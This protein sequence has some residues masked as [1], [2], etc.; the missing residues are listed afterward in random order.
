M[1]D[2]TTAIDGLQGSAEFPVGTVT[3][4]SSTLLTV[5]VR[6]VNIQ[7]AY[8][9]SYTA[10]LAGDLVAL[11]RENATWLVLGALAGVGPNS[12]VNPSFEQ[13]GTT[14]GVPSHWR[15]FSIAGAATASAQATGFA[16]DGTYELVVA[17]GTAAQDTYVYSDPIAVAPGQQWSVS[18]FATAS[19]PP[20]APT[21]ADI[22]LYGL[23]FAND[24]NLYPT[25][26]SAD[27]LIAQVN[28]I[29]AA[30]QHTSVSGTVTVPGGANFMRVATRS[31][32]VASISMIWDLVTARRIG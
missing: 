14:T 26:S 22:A 19:Y 1:S 11:G 32:A 7:A 9:K 31:M 23:W 4:V 5:N 16:V 8:L 18:A 27:T 28:N 17:S 21:D 25:T 2:L 13:D 12:V 30:P 6:G 3:A 15:L 29:A 24:T 10:P 20:A